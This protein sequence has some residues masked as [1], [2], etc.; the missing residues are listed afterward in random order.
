MAGGTDYASQLLAPTPE[1]A[2]RDIP[3][4]E[5]A[6]RTAPAA[7]DYAAELLE[8][9]AATSVKLKTR[10]E[11]GSP[12]SQYYGGL[13]QALGD[14]GEDLPGHVMRAV[15][16]FVK[17]TTDLPVG[18]AQ[19]VSKAGP[20]GVEQAVA[21]W[22]REQ[23]EA[24]QST[25]DDYRDRAD[26]GRVT[27]TG[28]TSMLLGGRVP[29]ATLLGRTVQGA[30]VGGAVGVAT[31]V[32]PDAEDY[33][34][35]KGAQVVGGVVTGA[36][37][38]PAVEG[39]LKAAGAAVNAVANFVR[40]APNRLTNKAT[41]D[42]VEQ[43]LTVELQKQG[44]NWQDLSQAARN[45]LIL[46]TQKALKSGGTIDDAAIARIADFQK[47][48]MEPTQGQVT[49]DPNQF[50]FERNLGKT[51]VGAP[52]AQRFT[53]QN[54]QLISAIDEARGATGAAA[55][56]PY[57]AGQAA[58]TALRT[59]D[60]ASRA[61]VKAA[62][63]AAKAKVGYEAEV[64]LQP[65]AQ[66]LGNVIDEVGAENI[67][68]AVMSRLKE[69]GLMEGK[70]TKLF[71]LREAEKLR[72]LI[73]NNM[74]GT[75][76][77]ADAALAPLKGAID[78]AVNSL[79][80]TAGADAAAALT[81]ARSAA[82]SRFEKIE[83]IPALADALKNKS[84]RP[85]DFVETYVIRGGVDEVKNLM[86]ALP[87]GARRDVRAAVV[88]WIKSKA[89]QGADETATF[90]QAGFNRALDAIGARNLRTIFDDPNALE[91]LRRIG[92]VAAN[93]QKAPVSSGVNYSSSATTLMDMLDRIARVPGVGA[94]LPKGGDIVRSTAVTRALNPAAP[95]KE[96]PPFL[97]ME[98]LDALERAGGVIA[99]AAGATF[100]LGP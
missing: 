53:E 4:G 60:A 54:R 6:R 20:E 90:S 46:E 66:R 43:T 17:G 84:V 68:A 19:L 86:G 78:E 45:A 85:E 71:T 30:K 2:A 69:F 40:G 27:G 51:E 79:A 89:V 25:R 37:A 11:A 76:S 67:P 63:D 59:E 5:A 48:R 88:D 41:Q 62:Y 99:P 70:Q 97:T 8:P 3:R 50:A 13:R 39:V 35:R 36:L 18:L 34:F 23:E 100:L 47:L 52:L 55:A 61:A 73:G 7:T 16:G 21:D 82:A 57:V 33:W 64:P 10:R 9:K 24:Y 29:A 15:A 94:V 80:G 77:P 58:Q 74:P 93:V 38:V 12:D 83:S 98:Q 65:I 28:V 75:R 96:P 31:P 91:Q 22:I 44:V 92:R 56:D 14:I 1:V 32:D 72:K 95:V 26:I 87:T 49:R 81:A 42:A